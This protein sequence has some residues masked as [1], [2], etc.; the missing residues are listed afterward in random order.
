MDPS[1][2]TT[3][4]VGEIIRDAIVVSKCKKIIIGLGGSCTND[5]GTGIAAALGTKFFDGNNK[6]F[7]PVGKTL[8]K[9]RKIDITETENLIKGCQITAMCDVDSPAYGKKGAAFVFAK[10]KG[11]SD[12]MIA[13]LDNNLKVL[14]EK[15]KDSC[16]TDVSNIKG[17]GACGAAG[18]SIVAF[19]GGKL[20]SGID[21]VLN[22]V[23][24]DDMLADCDCIFTG[25][26]KFD[27]QSLSGKVISGIGKRALKKHCPVVAVVGDIGSGIEKASSFGVSAVFSIN[28]LA[29]PFAKARIRSKIDLKDTMDN[30]CKLIKLSE[31]K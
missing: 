5:G 10:Q 21:C 24:F 29:I 11:A 19:L 30:I 23:K 6:K 8:N 7:V 18:A 3:F 1:L 22:T 9:I 28:H 25:E 20:E 4:G 15:I 2:T 31:Q 13:M 26:G 27:S 16:G 17:A 12:E 14:C